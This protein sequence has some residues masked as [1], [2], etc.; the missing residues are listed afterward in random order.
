V[1]VVAVVLKALT[2]E[3]TELILFLRVAPLWVVVV[4]HLAAQQRKGMD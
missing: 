1:V 3:P 2:M 4:A